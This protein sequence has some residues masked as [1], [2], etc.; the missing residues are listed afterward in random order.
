MRSTV[1]ALAILFLHLS[2]LGESGVPASV[3]SVVSGGYWQSSAQS[4]SYRVV[5]VNSGYEHVVTRMFIE[6]VR[7]PNSRDQGAVVVSSVEPELPFHQGVASFT[8]ALVPLSSGKVRIV[9]S[10]VVSTQ[11]TQRVHASL[12]A[13][14][15]GMVEMAATPSIERTVVGKP[16]TAA[17][18]ER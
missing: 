6:W 9:L 2:A 12:I 5:L 8:A 10:G 7:E 13:T 16:P 1:V 11:P 4:G 18:V 17:H 14:K 3:K 15:P